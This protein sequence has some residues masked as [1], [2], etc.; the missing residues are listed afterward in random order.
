MKQFNEQSDTFPFGRGENRFN[1]LYH[2]WRSGEGFNGYKYMIKA[3]TRDY[4]VGELRRIFYKWVVNDVSLP[5]DVLY[6]VALTDD[7]RFKVKLSDGM[8]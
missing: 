3:Y 8:H 7:K 5:C 1:V 2:E 6:K 4:S